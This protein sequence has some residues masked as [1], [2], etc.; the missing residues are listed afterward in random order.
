MDLSVPARIISLPRRLARAD[1]VYIWFASL[2]SFFP[3]VLGWALR[4]PVITVVGAYDVANVPEMNFGLMG[5]PWKRHVVRTICR[6]ST[7][8][9]CYSAYGREQVERNV[10][11]RTPIRLIPLGVEFPPWGPPD[12]A[13]LVL[14]IGQIRQVNLARK[15][16][17]TFA[18]AAALVPDARFLMVGQIMDGSADYLRSMAP[19]NLEI[20]D[21]VP[22]AELDALY[23]QA[24]VY[25]QASL[26]ESFSLTVVEAMA[27]GAVPV[28]SRRGALPDTAGPNAIFVDELDP[29]SVAEAIRLALQA[30]PEDRA[31][32]SEYARSRFPLENRRRDLLSLVASLGPL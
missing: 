3:A 26:H 31:A 30:T 12:R 1:L 22:Q 17:E 13:P 23:G 20:R 27:A 9:A 21:A 4:K 8:L 10:R 18:R 16:L 11:T 2:H 14:T 24:S 7:A 19:A 28:I 6:C 15:G 29:A 25:V 32:Y 5:H